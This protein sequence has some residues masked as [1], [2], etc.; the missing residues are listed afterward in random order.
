MGLIEATAVRREFSRTRSCPKTT[1]EDPFWSHKPSLGIPY[2]ILWDCGVSLSNERT[3][4]HRA[5]TEQ[6]EGQFSFLLFYLFIRFLTAL[7]LKVYLRR[8][9]SRWMTFG[10]EESV[11][12]GCIGKLL[13]PASCSQFLVLLFLQTHPG[14]ILPVS[15]VPWRL[16]SGAV[17]RRQA[18]HR[19]PAATVG[20]LISF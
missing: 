16:N 4:S 15:P 20:E 17:W 8:K 11:G 9:R 1:S 5:N 10:G 19:G 3:D 13:F 7:K 18:G 2:W 6:K 14:P 12:V